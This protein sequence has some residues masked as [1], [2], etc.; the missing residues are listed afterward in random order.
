M[1]DKGILTWIKKKKIVNE[2]GEPLDFKG[3][4]YLVEY[5]TDFSPRLVFQKC[6]QVGVTLSTFLKLLYL[7][8]TGKALSVIYT[9][10]TESEISDLTRSKFSPLIS[11]SELGQTEEGKNYWLTDSVRYKKYKETNFFFR[12][13]RSKSKAQSLTGDI[14]VKDEYDFQD[15]EISDL[16]EERLQAGPSSEKKIW[17]CSVPTLPN[18]GVSKFYQLSNQKEWHVVCQHC[19]R[20]QILEWPF[21]IDLEKKIF[22]CR[23]CKNEID[24]KTGFWRITKKTKHGWVGYHFSRLSALWKTAE[25]II[26]LYKTKPKTYFYNYVLGLPFQDETLMSIT[27]EIFERSLSEEVVR[28]YRVCGID[29]GNVYHLVSGLVSEDFY[30][31]DWISKEESLA[32]LKDTLVSLKIDLAAIDSLPSKFVGQELQ[33]YFSKSKFLLGLANRREESFTGLEINYKDGTIKADRTQILDWI[34]QAIKE[35]KI[36]FKKSLTDL[37]VLYS[38]LRSAAPSLVETSVGPRKIYKKIG[39]CDYLFALVYMVMAAMSYKRLPAS[40]LPKPEEK[41]EVVEF[42]DSGPWVAIPPC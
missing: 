35:R 12:G 16:F 34:F 41:Q 14:L 8:D 11:Y 25:E 40:N 21:S 15:H 2:R 39:D 18:F 19:S 3:H 36:R 30:Y 20:S 13:S 32:D 31:V 6:S 9:V 29:Q 23:Y 27:P 28:G 7:A 5:L 1:I 42:E 26:D 10:P 22:V 24:R 37:K 4:P 33:N 17:L 38:H